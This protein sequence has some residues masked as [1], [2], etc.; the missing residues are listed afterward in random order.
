MTIVT[1]LALATLKDFQRDTVEHVFRRLWLDEDATD[2]F[3]VADEVGLGK[4]M[5]AKGVIAKT[6]D[7]L[8]GKRK[9][10]DIVYVCSNSQIAHQNLSRLNIVNGHE[11]RHA[12]RLT[13]LPKVIRDLRAEE[14]NF[15]SF[16]P[17]TSF[18]VDK[19]SGMVEER[20]VLF[21]M[22][23][24]C[25]GRQTVDR[26]RWH[27]FFQGGVHKT[28]RF[29][30]RLKG[31]DRSLLDP[32]LCRAFGESIDGA[33]GPKGR[34]LREEL[35]ECAQEFNYL[36][37]YP[38]RDLSSRRHELIGYLRRLVAYAA[39]EHLE[40]DLVILDE[41]QRFKDLLDSD[42]EGAQL[43]K[44]VFNHPDAKLLLLS[45]T[46]YKMYT[47][48]DEPEG[49]DHYADFIRTVQFL[50]DEDRAHTVE[51]GLRTMRESLL[52]AGDPATA[53][54]ARDVVEH[55]LRRVMCRTERLAATPERDGMLTERPLEGLRL[56]PDDL[57]SW[58]TFDKVA[59][60]IDRHDV[61]EYWRSTPYPLNLMERNS[62]QV[63]TKF[64]TA[65]D[66]EDA[67]LPEALGDGTGLLRWSQIQSYKKVDPGNAKLRGLSEDVLDRG[68]WRLAWLPP[69]LP[70]YEMRGAYAD[71]RLRSFTKRL[72]FS[73]WTVVPKA[74]AVM[75][76]YEAE[77]RSIEAAE[78]TDR[79]YDDRPITPP[80]QYRMD[81]DRPG[82]MPA[83]A[84]AYPSPAL[85]R[86]GD[87][88]TFARE[89]ASDTSL[90]WETVQSLV[91]ERVR[92][93]LA[94][95]PAGDTTR[96]VVDQ[97]WYWAAPFLLDA[98]TARDLP[99]VMAHAGEADQ[100]DEEGAGN[101]AAKGAAYR[102]HVRRA[103]EAG[104]LDLGPR[105][106]ELED[107]LTAMALGAPGVCALRALSRVS[108]GEDALDDREI[109]A[110]AHQA[111][112]G[113]RSLFNKPEIITLLR[114]TD[115]DLYWRA[116]LDHCGEGCLQAV[117]DEF[118][119]VLIESEGLQDS[120][121]H[122]RART[123]A[124]RIADALAIRSAPNVVDDVQ[125][126]GK[127]VTLEEHRVS[128]HFAARYGRVQLDEKTAMREATVRNAF[129]SPFRPFVLASTSVGQEGLDFHT[130]S[131][132]VVHWNLPG[133]PVDLEQREGRVHRYKGHAVRKNVA[134]EHAEAA[135]DSSHDDPWEAMFEAAQGACS[136]ED[137]DIK[138]FWVYTREGGAVIE[139]YVPAMPLSREA[140]QHRRLLRTVGAYRLVIGQP[141]Q[142]D[143]VEYV[144]EDMDWLRIN[145]TPP[146]AP[147]EAPLAT[148]VPTSAPAEQA[149]QARTAS[150]V[151]PDARPGRQRRPLSD[152]DVVRPEHVIKAITEYDRLGPE[153]FRD[154]YGFGAAHDYLLWHRG[155]SYD[156]KA[157]LGVAM[158]YAEG[159]A[160]RSTEFSSG[161][162]GAAAV[163]WRLGFDVTSPDP[164]RNR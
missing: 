26:A 39:I 24:E 29:K 51:R 143:L 59:R 80:L 73:A 77:R 43:A 17:G 159:R 50:A 58:R 99:K 110:A 3:L 142:T 140:R 94:Q 16:T 7:H 133:N 52:T 107:V 145:L 85:A 68:A 152:F 11:H 127:R 57:R 56:A 18:N 138:P 126:E 20:V 84:L 72:V 163:L 54:A 105:P 157:I 130:Y 93:A 78:L 162:R 96:P 71:P 60:L 153:T 100:S 135:L 65:V 25:W 89:H 83:L 158:R 55:E 1:D 139:R 103:A 53:R 5:V 6:V 38:E 67:R 33:K 125:L 69:S 121:S 112:E 22:L 70:Y 47:L 35:G 49:D 150:H 12:D 14:V 116:V 102:E 79:K 41:F 87:P 64:Q 141:R 61:F 122:E 160:A 48:P 44:A 19:S 42:D 161:R 113:M 31:F 92:E 74:I 81:G 28:E 106:A 75:L 86:I 63:R 8:R 90:S 76:S 40:P 118:V 124:A 111:A 27:K 117:L 23:A 136:T 148:A 37:E 131:H 2:R 91:R 149:P 147:V 132:A 21:W 98:A 9:R 123:V 4:T 119:H 144:G 13:L 120:D 62:Y 10:I 137:S 46:P 97:R 104:S 34:P 45:A 66:T 36:R 128:S 146:R 88:L 115:D 15:V 30:Q 151:G 82:G 114:S 101:K 164:S 155:R 95:L 32:E 108:G 129:N 109:R 156:S 134:A 154:R